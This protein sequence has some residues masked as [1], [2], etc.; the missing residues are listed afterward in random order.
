MS[1]QRISNWTL[2]LNLRCRLFSSKF[3]VDSRFRQKT[4]KESQRTYRPKCS[5]YNNKDEVNSP[6]I[7]SNNNHQASSQKFWLYICHHRVVPLARISLTLSRYF[8]LSFIAFGES[9]GLH[10]VSSHSCCMY[11][12]AGRPALARLYV[13]VHRSTS[14]MSSSLHVWFV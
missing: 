14:L 3:C 10:S 9:S 13:W 11:V 12:R 2:Y 7:L 6:N 8:S 5:D 1:P 4:P